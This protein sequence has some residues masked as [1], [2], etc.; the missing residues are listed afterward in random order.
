[1]DGFCIEKRIKKQQSLYMFVMFLLNFKCDRIRR[2][3]KKRY[4]R[5]TLFN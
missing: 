1:M 4:N 2:K 5:A 3:V